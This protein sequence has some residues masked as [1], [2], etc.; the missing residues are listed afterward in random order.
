MAIMT[1]SVTE[2][3]GKA[4]DL[5]IISPDMAKYDRARGA[6]DWP[7]ASDAPFLFQQFIAWAAAKRTQ[8][9]DLTWSEFCD[10]ADVQVTD[11]DVS[12]DPMSAVHGLG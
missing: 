9:T 2:P 5:R 10:T 6:E 1:S 7:K 11:S 4:Y 12:A 3:G 8:Q